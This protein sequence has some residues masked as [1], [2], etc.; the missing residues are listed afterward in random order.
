LRGSPYKPLNFTYGYP[1]GLS[2]AVGPGVDSDSLVAGE[3]ASFTIMTTNQYNISIESCPPAP[4][5]SKNWTVT[6]DQSYRFDVDVTTLNVGDCQD[7]N[8]P[9]TYTPTKARTYSID[10]QLDGKDIRDDPY[11]PTVVPGPLNLSM[12]IITGLNGT[13]DNGTIILQTR[14][15][16]GNFENNVDLSKFNV[17]LS[18]RCAH[19]NIMTTAS[20]GTLFAHYTVYEGGVYC[21]SIEYVDYVFPLNATIHA[22]GGIACNNSC[23]YQGYCFKNQNPSTVE[24]DYSCSCF[25]GWTGVECADKM[26]SKYPLAVGAVVGLI[27]GLSILLFIIGLILGF[28][29]FKFMNRRGGAEIEPLI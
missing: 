20:A 17:G 11:T 12:T 8:F 14:D 21:P 24:T 15:S 16:Y 2:I 26:S 1:S 4:F 7:G 19:T 25:Q 5:S 28:V 6:F 3:Q 18:P 27:V 23:N 9:A 29:V 10:I 13:G 22:T